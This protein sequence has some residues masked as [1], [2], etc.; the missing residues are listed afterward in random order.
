MLGRGVSSTS[1]VS[2]AD[3]RLSALRALLA[4]VTQL[5]VLLSVSLLLDSVSQLRDQSASSVDPS[6]E[7]WSTEEAPLPSTLPH[8]LHSSPDLLVLAQ[9]L[10]QLSSHLSETEP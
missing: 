3:R 6:T 4:A 10:A 8:R 2:T 7:R 1:L 9:W 5:L